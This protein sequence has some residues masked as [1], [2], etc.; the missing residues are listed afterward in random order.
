MKPHAAT[1]DSRTAWIVAWAALAILT[2]CY[3]AP[4]ISVVALKPLAADLD[5][6][7]S[8]PAAAGALTYLGAAFGGI[9]AGWLAGRLGIRRIVL[10]GAAMMAPRALVV[11]ASGGLFYLYA[12]H[13][14]LMGLFGTSVHVLAAHH[15]CEPLVRAHAAE[16]PWR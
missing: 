5:A 8:G 15:L 13:G 7:R 14:V 1:L 4:L 3:G 9:V 16:P 11:S 2:L 6:P 10:F 12:G